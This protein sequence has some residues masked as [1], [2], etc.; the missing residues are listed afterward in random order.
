MHEDTYN[1]AA[2]PQPS[3][4]DLTSADL[5][6]Q[7]S[8]W[9]GRQLGHYQLLHMIGAGGMG[10]VYLAQRIDHEFEQRVAIKLVQRRMLPMD[11][12][13]RLRTERQILANLQHPNIARLFDGGTSEDGTPYLVMEYID[14]IP[15]DIYCDRQRLTIPQRLQLFCKVCSAVQYAHQSLIVHRDLKAN[16][17][18]VTDDGEPKL[19][20]FGIAKILNGELPFENSNLTQEGLRVMTPAHA[21][22]EQVRGDPITTSSDIYVLG[23]L[24]YELLC[25]HRAIQIPP[26][27][28]MSE[29]ERLV[30]HQIPPSPS[31]LLFAINTSSQSNQDIAPCRRMTLRNLAKTL[32]GDLDNI[33]MMALRK[34]PQRRYATTNQFADDVQRWLHGEPVLA[35]NDSWSYRSF[36][37]IRRHRLT[38][39]VGIF[40]FLILTVFSTITYLQARALTEQRDAITLERNR[41]Q[42]VSSFLVD[43][44]EL[45]D[46]TRRRGAD[47]KAHELL[48]LGTRRVDDNLQTLPETRA[49]L[50]N[51]IG[52]VYY[53]L[54]LYTQANEV[55]EKSLFIRKQLYGAEHHEVTSSI[56][57]LSESQIALGKLDDAEQA[58]QYSIHVAQGGAITASIEQAKS[59]HLLGRIALER[60]EFAT[61]VTHFQHSIQL[62]DQFGQS[63]SFD[64]AKVMSELGKA[65]SD[66]Y[67]EAEAEPWL[68]AALNISTAELGQDHP[69]VAEQMARLAD[70]LEGQG[71]YTEAADWFS[72][73]LNIKRH[74]LGLS[75]PDTVDTLE[76]YGNFMRRNHQFEEAR[77][78][79]NEALQINIKLYG[80]QHQYVGYDRVNIGL[81]DY[82]QGRY[83]DAETNFRLALTIY[84]K[85]I[86]KEHVLVAGAQ[87]G[88]ARSLTKL[89]QASSAKALLK[90]AIKIADQALGTNNPISATANAAL[91]IALLA[92]G[93]HTEA[94][95]LLAKHLPTIE[96]TYGSQAV[97]TREVKSALQQLQAPKNNL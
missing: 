64:K 77:T 69:F 29:V 31:Q 63:Q 93:Q 3:L 72:Q 13:A 81:L 62:F 25:G 42:Q 2:I 1:P 55:L 41:A 53:N 56:N 65:L 34:E 67:K 33:V 82:D 35:S 26:R 73:S 68:R 27:S 10:E 76:N 49:T 91:G 17:I 89:G 57:A 74:T 38:V 36:K 51:T 18:L 40:I 32:K 75:H 44:F 83:K 61:A 28:R 87:I 80:N 95:Q 78:I 71:K 59:F 15:I 70:I 46:P 47:I 5:L 11:V 60:G 7:P 86:S 37:F 50:L 45:S 85:S 39:S 54:G 6:N 9:T 24:L 43:L 16:N 4:T 94:S 8:S 84:S 79:L 92:T 14:G 97:I 21:S 48:D 66:Q 22:P 96:D 52:H 20:D 12:H 19:L 23:L 30:C 58:L 88:L 90:S